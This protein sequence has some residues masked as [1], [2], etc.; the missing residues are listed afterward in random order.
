MRRWAP[1]AASSSSNTSRTTT[2]LPSSPSASGRR[3]TTCRRDSSYAY[4]TALEESRCS[5]PATPRWKPL[6]AAAV[7][8]ARPLLRHR[9][10]AARVPLRALDS[11]PSGSEL[12]RPTCARRSSASIASPTVLGAPAPTRRSGR[13]SRNTST[14]L[15]DPPAQHRQHVAAAARLGYLAVPRLEPAPAARRG[16]ALARRLLRRYRGPDRA[17][18]VARATTPA[19]CCATSTRRRS[20]EQLDRAI[21]ALR[22][23]ETTDQGAGGADQP[24]AHR[25]P[26]E[27]RVRRWR[28][29][30]T[31][32]MRRDPRIACAVTATVRIGLSRICHELDAE[33]RRGIA[34]RGRRRP[35]ADRGLCRRRRSRAEAPACPTSTTRSSPA[36]RRS[37]IRCGRSR[38]AAS[39]ACA[40]RRPAASARALALGALVAVRQSDLSDWVLGVV[41]RLNKVSQRRGR[42]RHVDHRRPRRAR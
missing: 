33:G 13:S 25:D 21:A 36:C 17:L 42:G 14:S 38:I 1:T 29:T 22:Q 19:R 16:A 10:Q 2:A 7:R 8:A 18:S 37:P 27:S 9:R 28:P 15:L 24:A 32:N 35:R 41:R 11:R 40:S 39:L 6:L 5:R 26:R 31:P 23:A 30:S 12:H 3:S 34:L 4:Q 20:T